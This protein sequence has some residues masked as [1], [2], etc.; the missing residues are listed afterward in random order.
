MINFGKFLQLSL[1]W[2]S[3]NLLPSGNDIDQIPKLTK[4][5]RTLFNVI[6]TFHPSQDKLF[7]VG[8]NIICNLCKLSKPNNCNS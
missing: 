8:F 4:H 3:Q 7:K 6:T 1:D 5:L 2:Y